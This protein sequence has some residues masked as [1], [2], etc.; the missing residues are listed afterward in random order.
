M[1]FGFRVLGLWCSVGFRFTVCSVG[2]RLLDL[3]V[4]LVSRGR[5]SGCLSRLL[6]SQQLPCN[7]CLPLASLQV[8]NSCD[9]CAMLSVTY[10]M[11]CMG[12]L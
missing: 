1:G 10:C 9:F 3:V 12:S 11:R 7:C 5:V 2:F 8:N 4:I 6:E